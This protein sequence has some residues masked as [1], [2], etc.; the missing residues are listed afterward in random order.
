ML[1]ILNQLFTYNPDEKL[2][3]LRLKV[4]PAAKVN[5]IQGVVAIEEKYYLK[6]S[7]K[8]LPQDGKANKAIIDYLAK[9]W[10]LGKNNIEIISGHT[11]TL[12]S[13]AVKNI[14]LDYLKSILTH[15]IN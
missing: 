14:N 5:S 9:E 12:K 1:T 13:L 15:Y 11:S 2:A 10:N 6:I 3:I 8:A 7:I 4:K